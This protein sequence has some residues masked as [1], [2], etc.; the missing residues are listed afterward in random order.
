MVESKIELPA[1]LPWATTA[2]LAALV[3]C[4]GELWIIEKTRTQLLRDRS[5]LDEAALKGAENQLEAE[6][7]VGGRAIEQMRLAAGP[8][9]G[10][11]VILLLPPG[12]MSAREPALPAAALVLDA[13]GKRGL[14]RLSGP[15]AG[16]RGRDYRLWLEGPGPGYPADC[17]VF[18]AAAEDVGSTMPLELAAPI[19]PGCRFVLVGAD[20]EGPGAPRVAGA[21][22]PIV[23]AS[24]P[25]TGKIS[26]R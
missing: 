9:A 18:R 2:C 22:G 25:F 19:E 14:I 6:R 11:Q 15:P 17:G 21:A 16:D 10:P 3:A 5:Q 7:I 12:G 23:L 26:A 1:W 8:A 20:G 13:A 24:P 4:L